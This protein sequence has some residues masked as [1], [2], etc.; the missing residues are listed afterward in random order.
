MYEA[1]AIIGTC[2]NC[3]T[4]GS[5]FATLALIVIVAAVAETFTRS[6]RMRSS[7]E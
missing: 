2:I 7:D 6:K 3:V 5:L 1:Q 4:P